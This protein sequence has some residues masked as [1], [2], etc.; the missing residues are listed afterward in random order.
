KKARLTIR[1]EAYDK[2][3]LPDFHRTGNSVT[4]VDDSWGIDNL[5]SSIRVTPGQLAWISAESQSTLPSKDTAL[6]E[7]EEN[8]TERQSHS[9]MST[10]ESIL[11]PATR[12]VTSLD[13]SLS[14]SAQDINKILQTKTYVDSPD[15]IPLNAANVPQ[16]WSRAG[17]QNNEP[18]LPKKSHNSL[19][20]ESN[21]IIENSKEESKLTSI[22]A[23]N[24]VL[25]SS[26][27][28]LATT[29]ISTKTPAV[30]TEKERLAS[31]LFLGI[32]GKA[33]TASNVSVANDSNNLSSD[34]HS[35]EQTASLSI[36]QNLNQTL[37]VAAS[38]YSI[39]RSPLKEITR[40][41]HFPK[42]HQKREQ[43][44]QQKSILDNLT[45]I[46]MA[47]PEFRKSWGILIHEEQQEV[48]GALV[49][50]NT[51]LLKRRLEDGIGVYRGLG[52]QKNS[53][54]SD[55]I[56]AGFHVIGVVADEGIAAAHLILESE[57]TKQPLNVS[58]INKEDSSLDEPNE[59]HLSSDTAENTPATA[60]PLPHPKESTLS[61]LVLLHFRVKPRF[62]TYIVRSNAD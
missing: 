25:R 55:G 27:K 47:I 59:K 19:E 8:I 17:Y 53:S 30:P 36:P 40:D 44:L 15:L 46:Q 43:V 31:A 61:Y 5:G 48:S 38:Q 32:G 6:T 54:G 9:S 52:K 18:I 56:A 37:A 60:S 24:P 1:Y 22:L 42:Q 45:P 16:K 51:N 29:S 2:P 50:D 12:L 39:P 57:E 34:E 7:Y 14:S 11:T 62:C 49:V 33:K 23:I 28:S 4:Q 26:T 35:K 20:K 13:T 21:I 3:T 58:T 41:Y 10:N